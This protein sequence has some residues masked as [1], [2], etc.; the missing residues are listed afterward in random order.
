[1]NTAPQ[2]PYD[3]TNKVALVTGAS[4][5]IGAAVA[6][7]FARR[8]A[9]VILL[10]RTQGALEAVDDD[11]R[12]AG[13]KAT[14]MPMDLRRLQKIDRLGPSIYER[15]GRLDV[16]VGNAG[17]LGKLMPAHQIDR[18]DFEKTMTINFTANV[19]LIRTLDPLLRASDAGR[20]MFSSVNDA[21]V[22]AAYWGGY[23]ACKAALNAFVGA[24]ANEIK[25]T[26]IKVGIID[27]GA[28]ETDL[29]REAFPGG[30]AGDSA[31]PNDITGKYIDFCN[32]F[33]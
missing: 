26:K 29:R 25:N 3:F 23:A 8:G 16:V 4:R 27:P 7:D 30:Y 9:H 12:A 18:K 2:K 13:G 10:A 31:A 17:V 20:M 33:R 32:N 6:K 14:L 15:F 1:M 5:G 21:H 24:Y 19:N 22:P 11:I 28:V